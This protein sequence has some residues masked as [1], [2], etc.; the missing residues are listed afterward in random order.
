MPSTKKKPISTFGMLDQLPDMSVP[1]MVRNRLSDGRLL[2]VDGSMWLLR[3]VPLSPV[4]DARTIA[5][6]MNAFM[7]LL[8][9]YEELA[10]MAPIAGG[11]RSLARKNYRR[12]QLLMVNLHRLYTPG[13]NHPIGG[14]LR[15][16]FPNQATEERVLLM[17]VKLNPV[18]GGKSGFKAA[19]DSVA[20]TI[21][22]GGAPLSD[23]DAD[24]KKVD[25]ALV[26]CGFS[27]P[28][29]R[30]IGLANSWW[31]LGQFPDVV[32]LPHAD[33][34]HIFTDGTGARMADDAGKDDCST[35]PA[36]P[37]ARSL[38]FATV[39]GFDFDF[40]PANAG[41]SNWAL[42]LLSDDAVAVSIRAMIEPSKITRQELRRQ[43]KRYVDD[44][45]ERLRQNKM[46]KAEQEE[47]LQ[48]LQE[49]ESVY[50]TQ[51]GSPTL[52]DTSVL[53]AFDG[54][55]EDMSQ[56]G[57]LSAARLRSMH[58]RQLQALGEMMLASRFTANPN[59]LDL[60]SQTVACSG[61]QSLSLVGDRV[62]A[63]LGFTENDRQP[64]SLSPTA[65]SSAD[66]LPLMLVA[67][68]TGSGKS[69]VLLWLAVQMNKIRNAA[70]NRTQQVIIDPKQGSDHSPTVQAPGVDGE[71]LS[72]DRLESADGAFDPI[73]FAL[74]PDV[75]VEL[76]VSM[77]AAINPWGAGNWEVPLFLAL[78]H[79]VKVGG[80][81]CIGQAL[82]YALDHGKATHE[83]VDPILDLAKASP[84]FR[85]CVGID[86]TATA[87]NVS[88]GI[89]LIKVGD[90]TL[91]LPSPN[92]DQRT[93][94][95]MQRISL[96]LVRMM[97]FGTAMA[98]TGR[99]GVI[100][101]DEAWVFLGAGKE[102][103]DRLGRLARSQNV[104]P[105]L[106]TQ[107]VSDAVGAGLSGYISRGLI[108]PIEDKTEA[109]AACALFKLEPT[110][111]RIE[112]ITAKATMGD[113]ESTAPNWNGMRALKDPF[114][115]KVVRG[116]IGIHVDL[117]GRAVPTEIVL[118]PA[119]LKLS[120]T[121][122]EDIRRR[123]VEAAAA[124]VAAQRVADQAAAHAA[125][126]LERSAA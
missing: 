84:R 51:G 19:V 34:L 87:L 83:L 21:I 40:V 42:G 8:S 43:R 41:V 71:V 75:G 125:Q 57:G 35:W 81:T 46:E 36:I 126:L 67:G 72:L 9:A 97:V 32:T 82:T 23:Y 98:M 7:P 65:A 80:A 25:E 62:G 93:A 109:E 85:A 91:D 79:G 13:A 94:P 37:G 59:L 48:T 111:E 105:I 29:D 26:R 77:L 4:K 50:G 17:A 49:V 54:Q 38:S 28:S 1:T 70:G 55:V 113:G 24:M 60:P 115:D 6:R 39:E 101:L 66:G 14:Y 22:Y 100:H 20:E 73:R 2:G 47:M 3:R 61:I 63:L 106:Y 89:T 104:L 114:T 121:T 52:V 69:Q 15:E 11:R 86:P 124:A 123:E 27:T 78:D 119:F 64:V 102:E 118:S 122:P 99:G 76:A 92:V 108:L 120:S 18:V 88:D 12:T 116:S 53:V 68:A 45:N 10:T 95:L 56:A 112:R 30:E 5:E 74:T 33:H 103:V 107:R 96:A 31:N 44:I 90:S 58:F 110:A 16:V 117:A